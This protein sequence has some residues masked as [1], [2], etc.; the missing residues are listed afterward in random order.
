MVLVKAV[1]R[2]KRGPRPMQVPLEK[3]LSSQSGGRHESNTPYLVTSTETV[4]HIRDGEKGGGE[5]GVWRWG[6]TPM[7][8][9]LYNV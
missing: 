6:E 8:E 3:L 2:N 9:S 5:K 4:R 1:T 7:T